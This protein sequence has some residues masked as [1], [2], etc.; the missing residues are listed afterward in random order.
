M[1]PSG[2]GLETTF[3]KKVEEAA[4]LSGQQSPFKPWVCCRAHPH[5]SCPSTFTP[6]APSYRSDSVSLSL[7]PLPLK[8][9]KVVTNRRG[10]LWGLCEMIYVSAAFLGK[11]LGSNTGPRVLA[12]L[13]CQLSWHN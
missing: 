9:A 4:T 3:L 11:W 13:S 6:V 5:K 1:A 12:S 2:E 10:F 7:H 8:S